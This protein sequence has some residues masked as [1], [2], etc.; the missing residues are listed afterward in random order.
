MIPRRPIISHPA[1]VELHPTGDHPERQERL[2]VL[3][4]AFPEFEEARAATVQE[5]AA[6]HEPDYVELVRR[7]SESGRAVLLDPDTICTPSSYEAALLAAGAAIQAVEREGFALARPPGH[8][9]LPGRAMGFCLFDNIAVAARFAQRELGL[10]RVAILDWDVHHG[11]GTE[12]IF[13]DD[14]SVLFVSLHQW[15]FYPGSGGPGEGDETTVNVPLPAGTD[16]VEYLEAF[17][18]VALPSLERFAPD[19]LLVSAGFDAAAGDPLG[20]LRLSGD[21]FRA[22]AAGAGRTCDRLAL[23]LEGGYNTE[24]L[25]GLVV[26]VL[27]ALPHGR[28]HRDIRG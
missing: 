21:C 7:A 2:R 3:L 6:C 14:D 28:D 12:T 18:R 9:A 19:L 20:G 24:T 26:A 4:D 23:V 5:L 22:L 25:P 17:E 10:A 13:R 8:H 15:P 16:D 1:F 11:N 27:E